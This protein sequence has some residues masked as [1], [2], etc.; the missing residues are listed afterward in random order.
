MNKIGKY[1]FLSKGQAETKIKSLGTRIDEYGNEKPSHKSVVV[2]LGNIVLQ[3]GKYDER[4][5][6]IDE[7]TLSEKW[8]VDVL[9]HE[10]EIKTI[11]QEAVLDDY[12]EIETPE[13]LSYDHPYG[14][15]SYAVDIDSDGIHSFLG[16]RYSDYKF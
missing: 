5:N 3:K 9:W 16:L 6:V 12:G 13:I 4:G 8:H 14:W 7:P 2:E 11:E 10:D 1:E 15:K